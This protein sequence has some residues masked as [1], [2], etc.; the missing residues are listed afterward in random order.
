MNLLEFGLKF[1][2]LFDF[3][4]DF[5]FNFVIKYKIRVDKNY[6]LFKVFWYREKI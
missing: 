6:I 3:L 2:Y 1:Y 5:L 4:L